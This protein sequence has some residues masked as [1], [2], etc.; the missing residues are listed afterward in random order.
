MQTKHPFVI[1]F[2]VKRETPVDADCFRQLRVHYPNAPVILFRASSEFVVTATYMDEYTTLYPQICKTSLDVWKA[3]YR[4]TKHDSAILWPS[5]F[6]IGSMPLPPLMGPRF[7][8]VGDADKLTPSEVKDVRSFA[9]FASVVGDDDIIC[10]GVVD[11]Y[12]YMRRSVFDDAFL[13][14]QEGRSMILFVIQKTSIAQVF[15]HGPEHEGLATREY[16]DAL[17]MCRAP[18]FQLLQ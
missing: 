1:L 9:S 18:V 5:N 6:F 15:R 17:K 13:E 4:D 8:W 7:F 10:P 16:V 12:G 14:L 11:L 2:Y 3:F